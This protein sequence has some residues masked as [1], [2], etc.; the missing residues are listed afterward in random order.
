[1]KKNKKDKERKYGNNSKVFRVYWLYN[2][3]VGFFIVCIWFLIEN[4]SKNIDWY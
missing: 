4:E 3:F 2:L 1:M